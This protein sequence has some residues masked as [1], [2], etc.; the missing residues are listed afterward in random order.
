MSREAEL[1]ALLIHGQV[2]GTWQAHQVRT[3]ERRCS[4]FV[5]D[6]GDSLLALAAEVEQ[7]REA[8]KAVAKH[9]VLR[10]ERPGDDNCDWHCTAE[11]VALARAALGDG[12]QHG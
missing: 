4:E 6:Y 1:A 2:P 11:M 10:G 7:L 9:P 8:L 5:A 12:E 3:F